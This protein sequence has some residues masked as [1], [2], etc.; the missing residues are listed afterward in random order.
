MKNKS[1][2][3]KKLKEFITNTKFT[4][5]R[6]YN[7]AIEFTQWKKAMEEKHKVL[8]ENKTWNLVPEGKT[9]IKNK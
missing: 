6:I 8:I 9:P 5:A 4:G 1:N 7:E 3:L 2:I